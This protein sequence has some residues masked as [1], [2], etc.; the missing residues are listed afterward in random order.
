LFFSLI[1]FSSLT[2]AQYDNENDEVAK[3][4]IHKGKKGQGDEL[5]LTEQQRN[6]IKK[7]HFTSK[8][9]IMPL[10]HQIAEKRA[11]LKTLGIEEKANMPE[12]N[13]TIDEIT[14]LLGQIMKQKASDRQEIR[15]LLNEEQRLKFDSRPPRERKEKRIMIKEFKED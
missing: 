8:K 14:G 10:R 2:Y 9:T 13:K 4:G 11:H 1:I 3:S 12:I 5:K 15:K 6:E 7:I